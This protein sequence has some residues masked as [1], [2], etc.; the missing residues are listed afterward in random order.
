M[1]FNLV[2][3]SIATPICD[4]ISVRALSIQTDGVAPT[5]PSDGAVLISGYDRVNA[6]QR[7]FSLDDSGSM[8]SGLRRDVSYAAA[9]VSARFATKHGTDGANLT[10]QAAFVATT[11]TLML[12]NLT[13][14]VRAIMRALYIGIDSATVNPVR[15]VVIID[16]ADRESTPGTSVTPKNTNSGGGATKITGFEENPTITAAGA[17][18][19][20]LYEFIIPAGKGNSLSINFHD[21]IIIGK[22]GSFLVYV[23]D[24]AGSTGPN[25]LWHTSHE[26]A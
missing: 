9:N 26:E 2:S 16:S 17:G 11:P 13:A 23:F 6:L 1:A 14:T 8:L 15:V 4:A 12:R 25:I 7:Y 19:K 10:A 18:T 24:D 5:A 20:R 3:A 21:E 22:T